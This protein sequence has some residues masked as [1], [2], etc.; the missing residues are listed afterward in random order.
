MCIGIPLQVIECGDGFALCRCAEGS[1]RIDTML[2]GEQPAGAWLL[3]FLDTARE[4]LSPE[5]AAKTLDAIQALDLAMQGDAGI[6]HLFR[7][8]I[9]REPAL[10]DFL[11]AP[12]PD[13]PSGA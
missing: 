4:V 12:S 9:D 1:R 8:L 3:T 11:A 2:V 10:P 13:L 6:D 5:V 7:D